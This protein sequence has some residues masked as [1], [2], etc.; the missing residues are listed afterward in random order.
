M[1][2][3]RP[4]TRIG[5]GGNRFSEYGDRWDLQDILSSTGVDCPFLGFLGPVNIFPSLTPCGFTGLP[6]SS[7]NNKERVAWGPF[8]GVSKRRVT[9]NERVL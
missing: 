7:R 6:E 4:R 8:R 3:D 2:K 9:G 1:I 5:N